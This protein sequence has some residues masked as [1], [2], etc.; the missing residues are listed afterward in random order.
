HINELLKVPNA[1]DAV[2]YSTPFMKKALH[3]PIAFWR[4]GGTTNPRLQP[5][6]KAR[7][8]GNSERRTASRLF[9]LFYYEHQ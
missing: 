8:T 2:N 5:I 9:S 3:I 7:S 6:P 1:Y 4:Q